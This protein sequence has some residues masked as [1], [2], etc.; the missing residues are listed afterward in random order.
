M[1][2]IFGVT[3]ILVAIFFSSCKNDLKLNAPYKEMPS[4]YAVLNPQDKIQMIRI[5]KVF[6]GESNANAM[7]QV[8]DSI[9]YQPEEISVSLTRFV[10]GTQTNASPDGS[11]QIIF[12]DSVIQADAGV[13]NRNQ[14]VY[15]TGSPLYKNGDYVLTVYNNHTKNSFT[16]KTTALDSVIPAYTPF[17]GIPYPVP[18]D[19]NNNNSTNYIDYSNPAKNYTIRYKTNEAYI[20]QVMMRI[21]YYD[22]LLN[23]PANGYKNFAYA[24]YSF[25]NQYQKDKNSIN[26][27]STTFK[28]QSIYDAVADQ[29]A[30][31][32]ANSD[33]IGRRTYMVEFFV[34]SSTQDYSDY[35][36]YSS[37]SLSISQQKPLYSN[38]NG[39]A[40]LGIF[41]FRCRCSVKKEM[42]NSFKT[43]FKSNY[44]TCPFKFFNASAT[45]SPGC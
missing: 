5:N 28:G 3:M 37:P 35:L 42:D 9:N 4:I 18:P 38:F 41:T 14:R 43:E 11:T 7:A 22:S 21:H 17:I 27:L 12:R 6:L 23:S 2:Y 40:A 44:R 33:L 20:Y 16:A 30:K 32:P 1:K 13:F 8:A 39:G 15:V 36:Q 29:M 24:D 25:S 10:N 34:F 45:G 19:P 26:D 31:L